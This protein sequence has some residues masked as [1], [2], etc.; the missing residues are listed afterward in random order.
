MWS[1]DYQ[2]DATS[3]GRVLKLLNVVDEHTREALVV[4]VARSI[5]ADTTVT[6]LDH[7]AATRGA[8]EPSRLRQRTRTD[9]S[10]RA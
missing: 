8:P 7:L 4:H 6:V 10:G 9:R 5:D 2:F 3:D 1:L